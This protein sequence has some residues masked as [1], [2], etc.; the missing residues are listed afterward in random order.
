MDKQ[1]LN[2]HHTMECASLSLSGRCKRKS[3][4]NPETAIASNG[5]G[6]RGLS[7]PSTT[8]IR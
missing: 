4:P 1:S 6:R 3:R 7:L 5:M 8:A 2:S